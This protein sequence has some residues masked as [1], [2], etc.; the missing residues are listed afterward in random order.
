MADADHK[1]LS[2]CVA[3]RSGWYTFDAISPWSQRWRTKPFEV[4]KA[5]AH[6]HQLREK[7]NELED[8]VAALTQRRRDDQKKF[9]R[10]SE[11]IAKLQQ[12]GSARKTAEEKYMPGMLKMIESSVAQR[13]DA[14][15]AVV[16][17]QSTVADRVGVLENNIEAEEERTKKHKIDL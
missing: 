3:R 6:E 11:A 5:P 15:E 17:V 8:I 2:G 4:R 9:H 16:N 14:L 7:V 13:V 12:Q 1:V 10:M